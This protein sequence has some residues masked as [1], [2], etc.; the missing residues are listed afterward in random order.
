L[1]AFGIGGIEVPWRANFDNMVGIV[2]IGFGYSSQG[3]AKGCCL[4]GF[5]TQGVIFEAG[6]G[7]ACIDDLSEVTIIVSNS[8]MDDVSCV[9]SCAAG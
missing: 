7:T 9:G 1:I 2:V 8:I 6:F 4:F 3:C 5:S